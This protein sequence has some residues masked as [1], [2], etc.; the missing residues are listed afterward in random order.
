MTLAVCVIASEK[1]QFTTFPE[2]M[3]S[4]VKEKPDEIVCVADFPYVTCGN[5]RHE[6]V[7]PM[8]RNTIDALVK[9]DVG[10]LCTSAD[11]VCFLCDD[12]VLTPGFVHTFRKECEN[13]PWA[14]L[15]PSRFCMK[16]GEK[17]W[18]NVGEKEA[19]I[20][21]HAGIYHRSCSKMLPWSAGPHHPNWDLLHTHWLRSAGAVL[22]YAGKD[23]AV[24][25]IEPGAEPW[26]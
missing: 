10:W 9:R 22:A 16:D 25:D 2:V 14:M 20:G 5:W 13:K 12:H 11:Y 8:L 3:D 21:G 15:A 19:Y 6:V 7:S 17:L 4:V 1:R 24:E 18:L 23:L 26:M